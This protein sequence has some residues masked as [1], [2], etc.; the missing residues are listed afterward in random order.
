MRNFSRENNSM[1]MLLSCLV[2]VVSAISFSAADE[3]HYIGSTK[4]GK[5]C[6]KGPKKGKQWELWQKRKHSRAFKTLGT[7]SS[8]LVAKEAGITGDPQ[9]ADECLRCHVT[10]FGVKKE[11]IDPTCTYE[12]GV[13]CEACHGP[14]SNYRKLAIMKDHDK[15][16]AAGLIEQNEKLCIKCHNKE[17]PTYK[18]F[19][20]KKDVKKIA[21]P[22][23]KAASAKK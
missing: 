1:K 16:V 5:M 20:Y 9:K 23:P 18:P 22:K 13:G 6:H 3:A 2:V 12:E 17:S 21:H 14:G 19:S 15:A 10:A 11:L 8:K 4:C 7:D